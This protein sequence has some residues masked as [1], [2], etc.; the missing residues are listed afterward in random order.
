MPNA[1]QHF[2]IGAATGALVNALVQMFEIKSEPERKFDWGELLLC[3]GVGGLAA[4]VP[5]IL[6]P[7]TTPNHRLFFH[8]VLCAGLVAYACSGKHTSRWARVTKIFVLVAGAGYLSHLIADAQTP[9]SI[10]FLG[11]LR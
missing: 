7:A 3:S 5:D 10:P 11:L 9:K 2:I 4:L 1:K 6:E 8:S